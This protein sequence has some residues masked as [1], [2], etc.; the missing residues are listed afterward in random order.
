MSDVFDNL[1]DR[2]SSPGE[3][4]GVAAVIAS[5]PRF[6]YFGTSA[7]AVRLQRLDQKIVSGVHVTLKRAANIRYGRVRPALSERL[8]HELKP[9]LVVSADCEP[10]S[11]SGAF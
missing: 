7:F 6:A 11:A 4:A 10:T 3:P 5:D 2:Q 9:N 1:I 8:E